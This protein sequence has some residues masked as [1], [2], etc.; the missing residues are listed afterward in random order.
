MPEMRLQRTRDSY[1]DQGPN[2]LVRILDA[3][4]SRVADH[5]KTFTESDGKTIRVRLPARYTVSSDDID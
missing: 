4:S 3:F 2:D 5:Y 1:D